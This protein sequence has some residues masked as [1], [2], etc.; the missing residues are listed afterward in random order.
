VNNA[1]YLPLNGAHASGPIAKPRTNS[2]MPNV[3]TICE[4]WNSSR[5]SATPPEYA[6]E[7][8]ATASVAIATSIVMLHFIASE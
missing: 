3:P 5:I 4:I 2:E 8:K 1:R 6:E 7:T